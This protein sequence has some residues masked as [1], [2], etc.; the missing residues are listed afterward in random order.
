MYSGKVIVINPAAAFRLLAE[1]T[2][3]T[4]DGSEQLS[5][6]AREKPPAPPEIFVDVPRHEFISARNQRRLDRRKK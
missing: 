1:S 2:V 3:G 4:A 5:R 6:Y